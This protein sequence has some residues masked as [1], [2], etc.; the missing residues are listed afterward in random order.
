M[1]KAGVPAISFRSGN[2]LVEG[3]V[4]RGDALSADYTAKRYHQ[5][6]DEWQPGW[7]YR[8]IIEDA[9]LLHSL[10]WDLANSSAWPNWSQDS[11]F[12]AARDATA[13]ERGVSTTAPAPEPVSASER[14]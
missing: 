6:D 8:G 1:S 10:G 4:A 12:R 14:G 5:P 2:D 11:E 3:G 13:S 9:K 7:D